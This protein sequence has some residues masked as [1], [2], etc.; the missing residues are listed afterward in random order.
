M[1][2][3]RKPPFKSEAPSTKVLDS[4]ERDLSGLA[5]I[6]P[7][8]Q[9][10]HLLSVFSLPS[11]TQEHLF[12]PPTMP[13]WL[14]TFHERCGCRAVENGYTPGISTALQTVPSLQLAIE[15]NGTKWLERRPN[16]WEQSIW[17]WGME[18]AFLR[19]VLVKAE[20]H[21]FFNLPEVIYSRNAVLLHIC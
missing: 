5:S 21:L 20:G 11:P 9:T 19:R 1:G 2:V 7:L 18:K 14:S 16:F 8:P 13:P 6:P 12:P 17:L 3:K 4:E 15:G 10:A